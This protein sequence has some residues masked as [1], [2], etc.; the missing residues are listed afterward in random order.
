MTL[1]RLG[2]LVVIVS[3]VACQPLHAEGWLASWLPGKKESTTTKTSRRPLLDGKPLR[4]SRSTASK[5]PSLWNRMT[6]GTRNLAT[7]TKDAL[8]WDDSGSKGRS[9]RKTKDEPSFW[10]KLLGRDEPHPSKTVSGFMSQERP[11]HSR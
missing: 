5:D 11:E 2:S 6:S 1:P 7:K 3:L 10:N 8:T 4:Q 9:T